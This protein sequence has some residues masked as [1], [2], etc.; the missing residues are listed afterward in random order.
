[1]RSQIFSSEIRRREVVGVFSFYVR[2]SKMSMLDSSFFGR[3][4]F[5]ARRPSQMSSSV[6]T[7]ASI[8]GNKLG[9][10]SSWAPAK[11]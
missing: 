6:S 11:Q 3:L 2:K 5:L 4:L 7:T 1:M 8:S 9:K 10:N